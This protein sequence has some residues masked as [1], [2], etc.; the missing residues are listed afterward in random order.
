MALHHDVLH[1]HDISDDM[2]NSM[3]LCFFNHGMATN[4]IFFRLSQMTGGHTL[5]ALLPPYIRGQTSYNHPNWVTHARRN[6]LT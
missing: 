4:G 2:S 5:T 3:I 1:N 6:N